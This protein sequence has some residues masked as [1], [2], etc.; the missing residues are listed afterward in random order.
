MQKFEELKDAFYELRGGD[1]R[2][3]APTRE[4]LEGLD[5]KY[6]ADELD[7]TGIYERGKV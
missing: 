2:T 1:R 6:V 5:L 3:G 7:K 4:T